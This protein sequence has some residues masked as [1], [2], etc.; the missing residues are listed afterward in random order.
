[1]LPLRIYRVQFIANGL[2]KPNILTYGLIRRAIPPKGNKTLLLN[3]KHCKGVNFLEHV[4]AKIT[5][6]SQ[7]RGDIEIYLLSPA[8]TK[9]TLLTSRTHD[10][11]RSGFN[12]WPFM[13]VH[14]WGEAPHGSWLLEI[15]NEGH[16]MG[17]C[18]SLV[19]FGVCSVRFVICLPNH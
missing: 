12:Q 8:G 18:L 13:S 2:S 6:T 19:A 7:R 5:L 14:T 15:R 3:V 16:L 4:Q 10:V 1:M 17:K 11:S 9:V